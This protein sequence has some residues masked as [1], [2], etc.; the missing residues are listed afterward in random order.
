MLSA[1][2]VAAAEAR[3]AGSATAGAG[4]GSTASGLATVGSGLPPGSGAGVRGVP[5]TGPLELRCAMAERC[6]KARIGEQ[7]VLPPGLGTTSCGCWD[8]KMGRVVT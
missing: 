2:E 1:A 7:G 4:P 5:V 8:W 3:S 6:L